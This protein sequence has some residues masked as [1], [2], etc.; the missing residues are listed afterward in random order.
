MGTESRRPV[1]PLLTTLVRPRRIL[2]WTWCKGWH[3]H[4]Y[5][6]A[7]HLGSG[8]WLVW[9]RERGK[10]RPQLSGTIEFPW[11]GRSRW[12]SKHPTSRE[13]PAICSLTIMCAPAC[14]RPQCW[15]S[16]HWCSS[17]GTP[18]TDRFTFQRNCKSSHPYVNSIK[19][20][21][22]HKHM[23]VYVY[24][25]RIRVQTCVYMTYADNIVV[26]VRTKD[27]NPSGLG[28]WLL[29]PAITPT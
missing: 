15:R 23:Y 27:L 29:Q 9:R 4:R 22:S 21:C 26:M 20:V 7:R 8:E 18:E 13:P 11:S 25:V 5:Q 3:H 6:A 24:N 12:W 10:W 2:S 14:P 19:N 17:L 16:P 1:W 28:K